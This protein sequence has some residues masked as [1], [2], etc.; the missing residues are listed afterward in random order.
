M[1]QR[2][3]EG[4]VLTEPVVVER[5]FETVDMNIN[6]GPQH[7][8]THG[9]FRMVL[10]VD[11]EIVKDAIPYIGYMHRGGEKLSESLDYR[12]ALGYQDRTDYL[13]AFNSEWVYVN[14]VERLAG[15]EI[16]ERA[17]YIRLIL[18]EFNRIMSHF[19]FMGAFG[20]DVGYF[21]TAFTWTF[22]ERERIQDLFEAVCGDRIM[23]NY[24]R[25]GGLA[26]EPHETFIEDSHWVLDQVETGIGDV[27]DLMTNNEVFVA[28]CRDVGAMSADEAISFGVTGPMLRASGV[29]FDLRVDEPYSIYDRFHWEIPVGERGDVYDRYLVRLEEMRQSVTILRQALDQM[30]TSGPIELERMPARLRPAPGE[31]YMRQENPRGEYGIYMVSDGTDKPWRVKMRSPC[32]HNLSALKP[33]VINTYLADAVVALGSI[34][35]VLC[36]VDR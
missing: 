4:E 29:P 30:P 27:D 7:P 25:V 5:E 12:G 1:V 17:E 3:V 19:M 21:G 13:A 6:I 26:W 14:A 15:I 22:K 11:G 33:Q 20:T 23:Y 35:I 10:T 18:S 16:P 34:D 2:T 9:V 32:F 36:E 31:I 24:F 28:R 8:A